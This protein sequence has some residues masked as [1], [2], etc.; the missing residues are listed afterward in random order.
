MGEKRQTN[1]R[2]FSEAMIDVLNAGALNLALAIGYRTG[3]LDTLDAIDEPCSAAVLAEKAGLNARYVQEW[4]G[5]VTSAG[6]VTLTESDG[7]SLFHMPKEHG[8]LLARRA[9]SSNLGVYTQEIPLL[10]T[11][12]LEPVIQG[13]Y[14]GDGV[15]YECYPRFQAFMSSLA[16]AKHQRVLIDRFLPS[17]ENGRMMDRLHAGIRVCDLGC[18]EGVATVLMAEAFPESRFA[19]LDVSREALAKAAEM[20]AEKG[21]KNIGFL[22]L[23]AATLLARQDLSRAFDYVTA[24]DSIHDQTHPLEAL[25]GVHHILAPGGVFSMVD[26]AA[27]TNLKDNLGHAMAPFL[28]TVSLMHCMPVG[29]VNDGAGLGMMWGREKAEAML[30]EAGFSR[31]E[32]QEMEHDPF[33]L[34]FCCRK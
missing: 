33:N 22:E 15:G 3:L 34:H 20:A 27:R 9:G 16:E 17:V 18:G 5:I 24:F 31:V 28:Y 13:F 23:D 29:L 12:A 19:G 7:V 1:G 32:I 6:I 26:I 21:L 10:T 30:R 14:T 11:L 8:D 2:P 25:K 4:L